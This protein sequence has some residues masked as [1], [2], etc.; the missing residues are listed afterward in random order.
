MYPNGTA[1]PREERFRCFIAFKSIRQ[2]RYVQ[3]PR[4][5]IWRI[6][7]DISNQKLPFISVPVR[8]LDWLHSRSPRNQCNL[9][10]QYT[11]Q[12]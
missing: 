10:V 7:T 4:A 3:T 6:I 9:P 12:S 2:R 1:P 5:S 11:P 8:L